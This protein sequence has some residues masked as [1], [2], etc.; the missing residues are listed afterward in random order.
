MSYKQ[1]L[2]QLA[3]REVQIE[4]G[5]L[6]EGTP[7]PPA[8]VMESRWTKSLPSLSR[9]VQPGEKDEHVQRHGSG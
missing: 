2:Q 6:E 8:G 3:V 5:C 1:M 7:N 4:T 9:K